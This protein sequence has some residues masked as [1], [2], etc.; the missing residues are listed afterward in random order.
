MKSTEIKNIIIPLSEYAT[1][2]E[3]ACL[4]EVVVELEMT[5]E[6]SEN[7][8]YPHRSVVVLTKKDEVEGILTYQ[9]VLKALEP[10]YLEM[11]NIS[12]LSRF[13]ISHQYLKSMLDTHNLF[14]DPLDHICR[15]ASDLKVKDFLHPLSEVDFIGE[16]AT[17][18]E[19]I[20]QF[21]VGHTLSILVTRGEKVIGVL[22]LA[23][24]FHE[25][26]LRIKECRI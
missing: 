17:L 15:K 12:S 21:V 4:Y 22:R 9:D 3:D 7:N 5:R 25:I 13:G 11:G 20:H 6:K 16:D 1:V 24:V 14:E 19:V 8:L 10:K 26:S 18:N 23:D 2:H